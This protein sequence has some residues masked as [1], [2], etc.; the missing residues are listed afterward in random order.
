M[1]A[2]GF[3]VI[4]HRVKARFADVGSNSSALDFGLILFGRWRW[5][6]GGGD[7]RGGGSSGGG[8][9]FGHAPFKV[10]EGGNVEGGGG[11]IFADESLFEIVVG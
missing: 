5:F 2:H 8:E 3:H 11:A 6:V 9:G 1:T 4:F 7:G 10:V